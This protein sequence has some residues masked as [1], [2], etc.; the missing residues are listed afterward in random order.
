MP[1]NELT[2]S[3]RPAG[4]AVHEWLYAELR[5]AVLEGRLRRS[6][7]LPSSRELA[8]AQGVSR[9]AVVGVLEQLA[10]EGYLTARRGSGTRVSDRIPEDLLRVAPRAKPPDPIESW[11]HAEALPRRPFRPDQPALDEFPVESWM[12][13]AGRRVRRLSVSALSG[14]DFQGYPP[15]REAIADYLRTSRGVRCDAGQIA[16]TSGIQQALDLLSRLLIQPGDEA[17]IE[18]PAYFGAQDAFRLAGA[19]IV[20]VPVDER[21]LRVA[22]GVARAPKARVA[23]VTPGHQ[24]GL[25]SLM[26]VERRLEL[27]GWARKAKAWILEDDYDG[28]FRFAGRPLGALQGLDEANVTVYM[29]TFNKTLFP[30]LRLGY[31]V[32]PA[33]LRDP[34][35]RLRTQVDRAPPTLSQAILCDFMTEGRYGRHL[36]RMR[37][38]YAERQD[39]LRTSLRRYFKGKLEPASWE[40]GLCAPA[41]FTDGTDAKEAERLAAE[42]GVI[43]ASMHRHLLERTDLQGFML[44]FAA[45][46]PREIQTAARKL[47]KALEDSA[48]D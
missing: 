43:A 38:L 30:S 48:G 36:R 24:F 29:G 8:R 46:T 26:S 18:D 37:E 15:L 5:R 31:V 14:D 10:A 39:A 20:P 3:P 11:R 22:D 16:V 1:P 32:L 33:A 41:F 28:E 35:M 34:F 9:G 45:F 17:W 40:A 7:R 13:I 6:E 42:Q 12:R 44:G 23:Y 47:A 25:G 4:K 19:R 21:G 27:L 2:L